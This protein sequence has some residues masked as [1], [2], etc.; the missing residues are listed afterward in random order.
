MFTLLPERL[1]LG[2]YIDPNFLD[3]LKFVG[4]QQHS[5]GHNSRRGKFFWDK[6]F[7]G[8]AIFGTNIFRGSNIIGVENFGWVKKN[9]G[10]T[11]L[12][13][14][15][16]GTNILGGQHFWMVKFVGGAKTERSA[17]TMGK[18]GP[19]VGIHDIWVGRVVPQS[20]V[21][22]IMEVTNK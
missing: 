7:R 5:V 4:S 6:H 9:V 2:I 3:F 20:Y 15:I 18:R 1:Y 21:V 22:F 19:H 17:F 16:F 11:F 12:G 14:N 10:Q 13:V 8:S